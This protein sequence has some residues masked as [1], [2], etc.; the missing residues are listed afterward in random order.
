MPLAKDLLNP[1][2]EEER[3]R[4]KLKRL[5]QAWIHYQQFEFV[6]WVDKLHIPLNQMFGKKT[7]HVFMSLVTG[8]P[9]SHLTRTSWTSSAHHAETSSSSSAT[10]Q[11]SSS[12]LA[13]SSSSAARPGEKQC[14]PRDAPSCEN[15]DEPLW[16]CTLKVAA[17]Y[18]FELSEM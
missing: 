4:H 14:S 5:V 16:F 9:F 8:I 2:A 17:I 12:A 6:Y 10:P 1:P 11:P 18:L 13:A 7:K 3:I 15:S